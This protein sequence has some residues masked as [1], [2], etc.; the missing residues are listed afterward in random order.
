MRRDAA[1]QRVPNSADSSTVVA[2]AVTSAQRSRLI[3]ALRGRATLRFVATFTELSETLKQSTD[4]IDA[5][6]LPAREADG[7]DASRIVREVAL[8]R[9]RTAIIVWC[10][11]R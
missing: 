1:L 2:C 7:Q 10:D 9:P 4:A 6:V 5:V 8:G 11:A 3:D